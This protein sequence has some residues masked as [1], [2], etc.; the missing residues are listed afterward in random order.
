MSGQSLCK[1][2]A[3]SYGNGHSY[4]NSNAY[5]YRG[6]ENYSFT[7]SASHTAAAAL[8]RTDC[9]FRTGTRDIAS[10]RIAYFP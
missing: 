1:S 3:D 4:G 10:P 9:R 6:T 8:R 7:A 2:L 5:C